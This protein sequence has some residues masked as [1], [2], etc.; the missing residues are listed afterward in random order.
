MSTFTEYL[1]SFSEIFRTF[2]VNE[3]FR[4]ETLAS[5]GAKLKETAADKI[6]IKQ[7]LDG[8]TEKLDSIEK[9]M[10]ESPKAEEI[11][12]SLQLLAE[13]YLVFQVLKGILESCN[14]DDSSNDAE[15]KQIKITNAIFSIS[16]MFSHLLLNK[17]SPTI[18]AYAEATGILSD[19]LNEVKRAL[20][21]ATTIDGLR[22]TGDP[23]TDVQQRIAKAA[24]LDTS[25]VMLLAIPLVMKI[26]VR[27][28]AKDEDSDFFE[29]LKLSKQL[30]EEE[31]KNGGGKGKLG[32]VADMLKI[33][34]KKV[35]DHE[36]DE[37]TALK[38]EDIVKC[39][40]TNTVEE[41]FK[42]IE[43]LF[44]SVKKETIEEKLEN[45][46][47]ILFNHGWE[48]PPEKDN[49]K[50]ANR[51]AGRVLQMQYVPGD[52]LSDK[53]GD[54]VISFASIPVLPAGSDGAIDE[55]T[56]FQYLLKIESSIEN[57]TPNPD[58]LGGF[59]FTMPTRP[60]LSF[61]WGHETDFRAFSG[62]H[63]GAGQLLEMFIPRD[64]ADEDKEEPATSKSAGRGP[65]GPDEDTD[66]GEEKP[67]KTFRRGDIALG[68]KAVENNGKQDLDIRLEFK[69]FSL[70]ISGEG[71][72]G[73]IQKILPDGELHID[74]SFILGY[75]TGSGFYQ[76]G[77]DDRDGLFFQ[78]KVDKTL[79]DAITIS[80]LYVGLR[81]FVV[82]NEE[83]G[84]DELS[85]L[86]LESSAMIKVDLGPF[87][88]T[89]DRLGL[90]LTLD[91]PKD[92][93]GNLGAANLDLG[94]KPP[95][96]IGFVVDASAV[97]GG[98]FLSIDRENGQYYGA[99]E[100]TI[101]EKLSIKAV[102][103][104][105]TKRPDGTKGFSFL[106]I[107]SVEFQPAIELFMGIRLKGIGGLVAI[108]RSIDIDAFREGIRDD[109]FDSILF[110][111]DPVGNAP[112]IV[113]TMTT[114]FPFAEGR[115][116]FGLLGRLE[117]GS[118]DLVDM[119]I[120][121]LIE[122]PQPLKFAIVGTVKMIVGKGDAQI[123]KF[124]LNFLIALDLGKKMLSVDAALYD[125]TFAQ[126]TVKGDF[127]LRVTWG[128][129]PFF[130]ASVGG[131]HPDIQPPPELKLPATPQRLGL[132]L[133]S[134]DNIKLGLELYVALT[135]NSFQFGA[136]LALKVQVSKF[137]LEAGLSLDA[138]FR[139]LTDFVV[140][141]EG[142]LLIF[143]G[144]DRLAGITVQGVFSGTQP[145]RIRGSAT[146][147]I[148]IWDYDVDFDVSS[149]PETSEIQ[150]SMEV[151]PALET[152][153]RDKRN[154]R[155]TLPPG[156]PL[157]VVHRDADKDAASQ[158]KDPAARTLLADPVAR[159]EVV[160]Q[161]TP[162]G[163]RIDKIGFERAK[164][165]RKF[166]LLPD[167]ESIQGPDDDTVVDFFAPGM[168]LDLSD[169]EKISRKSF[170]QMPAGRVFSD[171]ET[172][173]TG[174]ACP[175]GLEF[176]DTFI[177]TMAPVATIPT[178]PLPQKNAVLA[179]NG[180]VARSEQGRKTLAQHEIQARETG[181]VREEF[182]LVDAHSGQKLE[183]V[184]VQKSMTAAYYEQW[185]QQKINGLRKTIV[186]RRF[187]IS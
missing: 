120:G 103:V 42:I 49:F 129:E 148:W 90:H 48:L 169:A 115:Y 5:T 91:F 61:I 171:F 25:L 77:L 82:K 144:D 170:E 89:V 102:A 152:A 165:F 109:R 128:D 85:G 40:D 12:K 155:V 18:G 149:G 51:V 173:R 17:I 104:I 7:D 123:I 162:L 14:F 23:G 174:I 38:V 41:K 88:T 154:W 73:F 58:K 47:L 52:V 177:D 29:I 54:L 135:S 66:A 6:K 33:I 119:K 187:D 26:F 113:S 138:L 182:V 131:W 186:V 24:F 71:R 156:R 70:V 93:N 107:V 34:R 84:A 69:D 112:A 63:F 175:D 35:D 22:P 94:L 95:S 81:P 100:L 2:A 158:E 136:A 183:N 59:R 108:H 184:T 39:V 50:N 80:T 140:N 44:K 32:S 64:E 179:A 65:A 122:V 67:A 62:D 79:F 101:C 172:V 141:F 134:T 159:I 137:R 37:G 92:G 11:T 117:W 98:G 3:E 127:F 143:W 118:S 46:G 150:Q 105:L 75:N 132:A 180:S 161:V 21:L 145:W 1:S 97:K 30:L 185:K 27:K 96:G 56:P 111:D 167:D 74:A 160:Q 142:K 147:S 106:L 126:I 181:S 151:L 20:F 28:K 31:S 166:D 53:V 168:F 19:E 72:D 121:I 130:L 133:M 176:E 146:F 110:P 86:T 45:F 68:M 15:G 153:V 4:N 60:N 36:L 163:V 114:L 78:F 116:A 55:N 99:A 8:L 125:S 157:H 124:K 76:E 83:T 16:R 43:A 9:W 57:L 10:E 13:Y 164:D 139:S 178:L 87:R